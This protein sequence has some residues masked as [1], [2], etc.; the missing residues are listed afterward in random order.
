MKSGAG[1][2][3]TLHSDPTNQWGYCLGNQLWS[4]SRVLIEYIATSADDM[5]GKR[6]IELGCGLGAVG[7]AVGML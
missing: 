6:V 1:K 5:V 7:M 3:L 4:A 2:E